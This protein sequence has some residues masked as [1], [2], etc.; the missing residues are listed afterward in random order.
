M[1][2][3]LKFDFILHARPKKVVNREVIKPARVIYGWN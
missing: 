1:L 3:N 2:K